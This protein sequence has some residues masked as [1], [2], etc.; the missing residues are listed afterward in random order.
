MSNSGYHFYMQHLDANG[1]LV[2][3]TKKDL[4]VDFN[5][6]KYSSCTGLGDFGKPKVYTEEYADSDSVRVY[7][8]EESLHDSNTVVFNFFFFGKDRLDVFNSFVEYITNKIVRYWDTARNR[9]L[10]FYVQNE[11]K[12]SNEKW[13][14][15]TPYFQATITVNNVRGY[16]KKI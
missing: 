3:N 13:Y 4:E 6:L 7:F 1:N 11:I 2:P 14:A 12:V 15:G 8:P 5:G 10:D 16:T 9:E